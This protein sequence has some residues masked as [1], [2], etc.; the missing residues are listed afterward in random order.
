MLVFQIR[1]YRKQLGFSVGGVAG[2]GGRGPR[3]AVLGGRHFADEK[4]S[5]ESSSISLLF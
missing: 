2:G 1:V 3:A 5:F 4:L